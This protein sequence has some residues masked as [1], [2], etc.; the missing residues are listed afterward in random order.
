MLPENATGESDDKTKDAFE[1]LKKLRID[2]EDMQKELLSNDLS[3]ELKNELYAEVERAK[4]GIRPEERA[5][6]IAN[7]EDPNK[8]VHPFGKDYHF[9]VEGN[10]AHINPTTDD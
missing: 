4:L 7:G 3:E 10:R 9:E 6:M 1:I 2:I 5:G 8:N